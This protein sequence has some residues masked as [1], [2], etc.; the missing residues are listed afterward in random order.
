MNHI[1]AAAICNLADLKSVRLRLVEEGIFLHLITIFSTAVSLYL[2]KQSCHILTSLFVYFIWVY[3]VRK[4]VS[5]ICNGL[6]N[7]S[8]H[9]FCLANNG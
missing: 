9:G 7:D 8:Y 6:E 3:I 4:V 5:L 1:C 2:F